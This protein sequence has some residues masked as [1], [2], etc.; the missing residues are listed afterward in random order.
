MAESELMRFHYTHRAQA[1]ALREADRVSST[2]YYINRES[3]DWSRERD[4]KN[5]TYL[6]MF[7]G[8]LHFG[9]NREA[10]HRARELVVQDLVN[11]ARDW[12]GR[13]LALA[14][15]AR[16]QGARAVFP[17]FLDA[18]IKARARHTHAELVGFGRDVV[19][20]ALLQHY[21]GCPDTFR[22]LVCAAEEPKD[23]SVFV[24]PDC[25]M[26]LAEP[27]KDTPW[28]HTWSSSHQLTAETIAVFTGLGVATRDDLVYFMEHDPTQV[29][30]ACGVLPPL[31]RVRAR[32]A[33]ETLVVV[34][35]AA[36]KNNATVVTDSHTVPVG[37]RQCQKCDKAFAAEDLVLCP[38][39]KTAVHYRTWN[40]DAFHSTGD[41]PAEGPRTFPVVSGGEAESITSSIY[42]GAIKH[43]EYST[44]GSTD[45][46]LDWCDVAPVRSSAPSLRVLGTVK[47]A[48]CHGCQGKRGDIEFCIICAGQGKVVDPRPYRVVG[49][50]DTAGNTITCPRGPDALHATS[51]R[52]TGDVSPGFQDLPHGVPRLFATG[53]EV[54]HDR[55]LLR[56]VDTGEFQSMCTTARRRMRSQAHPVAHRRRR[57]RGNYRDIIDPVRI[58]AITGAIH[59][60]SAFAEHYGEVVVSHVFEQPR[61]PYRL[62]VHVDGYNS[63]W[64][65]NRGCTP[66]GVH[67][68]PGPHGTSRVYFILDPEHGI[69][70][71]CFSEKPGAH[72]NGT[73][74]GWEG[75]AWQ[76]LEASVIC[77]L[78]SHK[79]A[80]ATTMSSG[81]PVRATNNTNRE[82][83]QEY[84]HALNMSRLLWAGIDH[85][86]AKEGMSQLDPRNF[87]LC[88]GAVA[89]AEA[90][91]RLGGHDLMND[92]GGL[93]EFV[94]DNDIDEPV[95][96]MK[97][98]EASEGK[99]YDKKSSW[100]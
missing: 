44:W 40:H 4:K 64:C 88:C 7:G 60:T 74:R 56:I 66:S 67:R 34:E 32:R 78:W 87:L 53:A 42:L 33:L 82:H 95:S 18:D 27:E 58:H 39:F 89:E 80:E 49:C 25:H 37:T 2:A 8:T 9:D 63:T 22:L 94:C 65:W 13:P 83:T 96:T 99:E 100:T 6:S 23:V 48:R 5:Y 55:G 50:L 12:K 84:T 24:C 35:G 59:T 43:P 77:R 21:P 52:V 19:L 10:E 29:H 41:M 3:R 98:T 14:E 38:A 91:T 11:G 73:C 79:R 72:G 70:Q 36:N 46:W 17:F 15:C 71:R 81:V 69:R 57:P 31:Q 68:G 1:G 90:G 61:K 45:D 97:V 85:S 20:P 47:S 86:R 75:T 30:V 28:L 54:A 26:C 93:Y 76:P 92:W 16:I 51:I 62:V